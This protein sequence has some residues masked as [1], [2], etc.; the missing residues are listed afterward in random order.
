MAFIRAE[1]TTGLTMS[2][3]ALGAGD[4]EQKRQRNHVNAKKAYDSILHFM[5][6]TTL[7]DAELDEVREALKKLRS[8]LSQLGED[9]PPLTL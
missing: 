1:L 4:D 5:P 3:I 6:D 2:G 8:N 7:T 9:L